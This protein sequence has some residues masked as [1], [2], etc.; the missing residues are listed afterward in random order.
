M[1]Q[2]F[3]FCSTFGLKNYMPAFCILFFNITDSVLFSQTAAGK[4]Q[5]IIN[6]NLA[7]DEDDGLYIMYFNQNESYFYN[8]TMPT[9]N[10]MVEVGKNNYIFKCGDPTGKPT[11]KNLAKRYSEEKHHVV[12]KQYLCVLKDTLP[13]L[14]WK[15]V[16]EY[17]Q[18]SRFKAQKATC[19]YGGRV[20]DAWF[21]PQI[22]VSNG[23]YRLYGLPGMI[24]EATSRDGKINVAFHSLSYDTAYAEQIVPL[25]KKFTYE[26]LDYPTY[27]DKKKNITKRLILESKAEGGEWLPIGPEIDYQVEKNHFAP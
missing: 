10:S 1:T 24:L 2:C 3:R 11:Y 6:N 5:Y 12:T 19:L 20:I 17:K 15:L 25:I 13:S 18:I 8:S 26:P 4:I 23:P 22:P 27:L 9:Q 16:N 14:Q 21:T 7:F